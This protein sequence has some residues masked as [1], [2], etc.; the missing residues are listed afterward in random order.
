MIRK[1]SYVCFYL[2]PTAGI[3]LLAISFA[4][5]T[6]SLGQLSFRPKRPDQV[7]LIAKDALRGMDQHTDRRSTVTDGE[8]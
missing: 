8:F 5:K 2:C 4:P 6:G 3:D 7:G 1:K